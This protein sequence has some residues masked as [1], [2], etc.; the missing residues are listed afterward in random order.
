MS[1]EESSKSNRRTTRSS[2][3]AVLRDSGETKKTYHPHIPTLNDLVFG[4][5]TISKEDLLSSFPGRHAQILEL[6][7]L[8]GPLN[9]PML[10]LFVYG[11]T[12]SGK[13]SVILQTFRHLNRPFVYSSCRTCYNLR[14]LFESILNQLLLHQKD[15]GS[16]YLSAKRCEK[17]SDFVNFLREAL[18]KVVNTL[19]GNPGKLSTKKLT[20]QGHGHMIYLIFD[21]LELVRNWDKSS[22]ILPFLFNLHEVLNMNEVGFLFISNTSPDTYYS[23]MGYLEPIPVYFFEYTEDDLR[24]ILSRNQTNQEMY[25]SFLSIVLGP[26][27]RI[28]RQVNE[29]SIAFSSLYKTYR[30]ASGDLNNVPNESSKRARFSHFQPHIAPALN[31]I[32]K[33]SSQRSELNNLK[34]PKRKGGSKKLGGFDS[35]EDLDFHMSTSAKYLLLSAFLASRNPATLDAS[36][37]D[38]TGGASSRKRK[39]R[40]SEKAIEQKEISEQELLMKGPGTFPLER[41]LAIFQCITSVAETSLEDVQG[42]V[43]MESQNEDSELMS[44]VLL[45]LSS[46]CNANFVVKGGSCPLEG[47]TRYRSTVSEDMASKVARSIKFPLSKYMYRR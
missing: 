43:V 39:K 47:S 28:T 15:A 17:P 10:P 27:C 36:L 18:V 7:N 20:G 25:S 34:E 30:E 37:F 3:A 2:A 40:P 13:T 45:Q 33:I 1:K 16:G 11:G 21:N 23:N 4:E 14:T 35:S 31:Q 22:S 24:Q 6:L 38:S 42:D 19:Q 29:L 12:S 26:F 9:S 32:F 44:D 46:L 5:D 8:L 41:L